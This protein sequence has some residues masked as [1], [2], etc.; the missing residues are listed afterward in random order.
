MNITLAEEFINREVA[1]AV[2]NT[3]FDTKNES[4]EVHERK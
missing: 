4:R 3:E 2:K 1:R